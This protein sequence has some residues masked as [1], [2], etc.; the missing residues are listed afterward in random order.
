MSQNQACEVI[1]CC[2]ESLSSKSCLP[3]ETGLHLTSNG[4]MR[5]L[6]CREG[7][8]SNETMT[9]YKCNLTIAANSQNQ[10]F[11]LLKWKIRN[12]RPKIGTKT[13]SVYLNVTY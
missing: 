1:V 13:Y 10:K 4:K 11:G 3:N 6:V 7:C 2:K 8:M 5:S 12:I 9:S